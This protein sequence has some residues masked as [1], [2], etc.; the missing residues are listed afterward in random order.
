ML[1]G[2]GVYPRNERCIAR[3]AA[4][5]QIAFVQTVAD[6]LHRPCLGFELAQTFDLRRIGLLYYVAA[7]SETLVE[8]LRRIERFSGVGNEAVQFSCVSGR[9]LEIGFRYRGVARHSDRHQGEFFLA[10]LLRVC[11]QLTGQNLT[12][13]RALLSHVRSDD[14]KQYA[15]FF[16]VRDRLRGRSRR[17]CAR[18]GTREATACRRRHVPQSDAGANF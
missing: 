1:Q 7:S 18:Q 2:I 4:T 8:A 10:A 16:W 15:A 12:P 9:A 13:V 3:I 11:R 5:V 6:M 17:N 14:R